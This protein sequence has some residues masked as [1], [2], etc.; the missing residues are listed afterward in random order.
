MRQDPIKPALP[1]RACDEIYR[2]VRIRSQESGR[3][4]NEPILKGQEAANQFNRT[5]RANQMAVQ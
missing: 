2:T 3:G 4:G 5:S 1:R